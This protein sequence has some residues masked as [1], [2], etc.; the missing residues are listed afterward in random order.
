MSIP[1]DP[2]FDPFNSAPISFDISEWLHTTT[3]PFA[4]EPSEFAS[5]SSSSTGNQGISIDDIKTSRR[6]KNTESARRS[7][8]KKQALVDDLKKKVQ[9]LQMENSILKQQL[10][11]FV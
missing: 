2:T 7:R 11:L 5:T 9:E 10:S 8:Q 1:F 4:V 6:T 3:G